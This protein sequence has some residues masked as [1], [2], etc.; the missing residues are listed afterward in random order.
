MNTRRTESCLTESESYY[1]QTLKEAIDR[2]LPWRL[3]QPGD[4]GKALRWCERYLVIC[5][6]MMSWLMAD[7]LADR[8][9]QARQVVTKMFPGRKRPG[10]TYQGFV[11]ALAKKSE[12]LLKTIS[13]HL[14][15]EVRQVAGTDHWAHLGFVPFGADG[16]KVECPKTAANEREFGCAGKKKSTP[17]QYVTTL[18]HLPTGVVWEFM[19]GPAR[20]S[21]RDHLRQMLTH[22]RP[23]PCWSPMR[24][25][26]ATTCCRRFRP[27]ATRS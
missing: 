6:L 2:H 11:A 16:S 8:F 17:R 20:S 18:L 5:A 26:P 10:G 15:G 3:F 22:C 23:M 7:V 14:R 13:E 25:S 12:S 4:A 9:D 19:T 27:R 21:E 24:G 1:P